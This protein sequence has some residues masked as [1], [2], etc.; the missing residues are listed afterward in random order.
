MSAITLDGGLVHY[1]KLGRGLPVILIHGWIG[2]W[3]YWVPTMQ[4]LYLKYGVYGIDLFGFGDSAKNPKFYSLAAQAAMINEFMN[5]LGIPKAAFIGHGLGTMV[6]TQFARDYKDKAAL[7]LLANPPLFDPGNLESRV[8][9]GRRVPLAPPQAL[10]SAEE[11]DRLNAELKSAEGEPKPEATIMNASTAMRAALQKAAEARGMT[12][13]AE[14]APAPNPT[15]TPAPSAAPTPA[16]PKSTAEMAKLDDSS[17][18]PKSNP[19]RARINGEAEALLAKSIRRS[20]P[21]YEKFLPDVAKT[22]PQA[23]TLSV[24]DFD[25][26]WMLDS[27]YML[28][29]PLVVLYGNDDPLLDAP[30]EE[31]LNWLIQDKENTMLLMPLP[32]VKHFPM[33]EYDGFSRVVNEF[34]EKRD[35]NKIE[36]K[37]RWRR[38]TR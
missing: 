17:V 33:L 5:K 27:L 16:N 18:R 7:V 29:V 9:P 24:S 34:L 38:R 15:P 1:E 6:V 37:E 2:S 3:R 12:L 32:G 26:G 4:Q 11:I 31:V 28:E 25:S 10:P 30:S 22:D 21:V 14:P 13:G 36:V 20:D 8:R 19:L 35:V 23:I